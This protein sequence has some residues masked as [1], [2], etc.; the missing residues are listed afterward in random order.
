V[1]YNQLAKKNSNIRRWTAVWPTLR[2]VSPHR[3]VS[4]R[5][6]T[7]RAEFSDVE[8][9]ASSTCDL[10]QSDDSHEREGLQTFRATLPITQC[11]CTRRRL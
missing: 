7:V 8:Q 2:A 3:A 6:P 5:C 9:N 10:T 11:S 1:E 4:Q